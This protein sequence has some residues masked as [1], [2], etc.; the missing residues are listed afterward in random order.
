MYTPFYQKDTVDASVG[1]YIY[2]YPCIQNHQC[3]VLPLLTGAS[4]QLPRPGLR[5]T[6]ARGR[7]ARVAQRW[8]GSGFSG[9]SFSQT[10]WHPSQSSFH[11][12][13]YISKLFFLQSQMEYCLIL[14]EETLSNCSWNLNCGSYV[15]CKDR[16]VL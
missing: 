8:E 1:V 7:A 16:V 14:F 10:Q 15:A 11:L 5:R 3:Y 6:P 4:R 9:F 2:T 13:F 12:H